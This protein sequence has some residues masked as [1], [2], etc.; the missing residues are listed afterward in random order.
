MLTSLCR[1]IVRIF[2]RDIVIEGF[3]N[4]PTTGPVIVTPNHPNALLDPL[5]LQLLTPPL[6]LRFVAKASLFR[7]PV[8]GWVLRRLRA[9]PVVRR[10]DADGPVDYTAFFSACIEALVAG[11]SIAIFPEGRSLPHP[12][13]APLRTGVARLFFLARAKGVDVTIVPVGLNYE[14]GAIFRTSVLITVAPPLDAAR[15]IARHETDADGGVRAVIVDIGRS[16]EQHVFQAE[17]FRD[18]ELLLLLERLYS[19]DTHDDSWPKRFARLKTFET[20]LARLREYCP[21]EIDRLRH[22]LARYARLSVAFGMREQARRQRRGGLAKLILLEVSGLG[23]ASIGW[24]LNWLPYRLCGVLV[25]LSGRDEA[26][27]ATYKV[28]YALLLFPLAYVL[29]G[30]LC[31]HWFGWG[32]AAVFGVGIIPL[33]YFTLRF[34]E[35]C[36]ARGAWPAA[37]WGWFGRIG[38]HRATVHLSRLR[39]RIVAEV[40]ALAARPELHEGTPASSTSPS[41]Q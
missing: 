40:D 37:P 29:E 8:L 18:R 19:E 39:Q 27:A 15:Y 38:S 41:E 10:L 35:W 24:V 28:V 14:R 32:V 16:L 36:K 17:T 12:F 30:V 22:R 7:I 13:M 34:F 1:L 33:S 20:A 6:R 23:V 25:R 31:A 3:E 4:L 11:D 26:E 21:H 2:F 9:L 5:V